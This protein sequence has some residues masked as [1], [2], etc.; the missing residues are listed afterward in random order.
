MKKI[1]TI[2]KVI[3]SNEYKFHKK[4]YFFITGDDGDDYFAGIDT[5]IGTNS[6]KNRYVYAGNRVTFEIAPPKP[7][8]LSPRA[9]NVC[10]EKTI[11]NDP[12]IFIH[13]NKVYREI[14][15]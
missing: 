4:D 5:V 12:T 11:R 6:F 13:K 9:V 15:I 2:R 14:H 7:A 1:G 8:E 3:K 10:V